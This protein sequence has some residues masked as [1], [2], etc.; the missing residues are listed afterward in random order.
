MKDVGFYLY[1]NLVS[2]SCLT[3]VFPRSNLYPRSR[4]SNKYIQLLEEALNH[5]DGQPNLR[6]HLNTLH[7]V[8]SLKIIMV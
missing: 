5:L 8:R 6:G 2:I 7:R 3:P 4:R 1:L